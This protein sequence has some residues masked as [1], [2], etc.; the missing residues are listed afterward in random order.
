MAGVGAE[1]VAGVVAAGG[2]SEAGGGREASGG[3]EAGR[4]RRAG[5]GDCGRGTRFGVVYGVLRVASRCASSEQ[6]LATD[7]PVGRWRYGLVIDTFT[8]WSR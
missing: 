7:E 1:G 8:D 6:S 2:G 4:E 5:A 3:R